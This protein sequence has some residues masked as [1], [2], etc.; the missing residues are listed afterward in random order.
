MNSLAAELPLPWL[1]APL[2]RFRGRLDRAQLPQA[3]CVHGPAGVG[4][5]QLALTLAATLLDAPWR[6]PAD[7]PPGGLEPVPH[8]DFWAV[9]I[10]E[11]SRQIKVDQI[12]DL[13]HHLSLTSHGNGWRVGLIWPADAM[14]HNAANTLLKTLEEPRPGTTLILVT[15][16]LASLPPTVISRC[17]RLRLAAPPPAMA[18][19]WLVRRHPDR[20]ACERALAFASG[21][22][23]LAAAVLGGEGGGVLAELAAELQQLIDRQATPVAVG[24]A[25][26]RRDAGLCLRWLYLETAGLIRSR[27]AGTAHNAGFKPLKIP[28]TTVNMTA[29][30]AHLD[31]IREAQRLKDRSLNMDA[32][33]ADLLMWWYGAAGAAR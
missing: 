20:A 4:R 7:L 23:L 25:W 1:E 32:V 30:C 9:G 5:R 2:R 11:D 14:N 13:I 17:E 16:A 22:P 18:L 27:L 15:E 6:P 21:A 10:E 33:F 31:Q 29:C 8:P 24:H 3:L 28:G 26:A 12:R 19:D